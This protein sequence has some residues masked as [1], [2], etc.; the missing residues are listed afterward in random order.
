MDFC[1]F[2]WNTSWHITNFN[3]ACQNR[4]PPHFIWL[5]SSG[6]EWRGLAHLPLCKLSLPFFSLASA[7]LSFKKNVASSSWNLL[8]NVNFA[9]FSILFSKNV[10]KNVRYVKKFE[11]ATL[12]TVIHTF[13]SPGE[14]PSIFAYHYITTS[15]DVRKLHPIPNEVDNLTCWSMYL[16]F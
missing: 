3:F 12:C 7:G 8:D 11:L 1:N 10:F 2:N 4:V 13:V 14:P 6:R 15:P 9:I 16:A 5:H